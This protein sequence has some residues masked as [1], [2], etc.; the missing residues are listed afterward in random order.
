MVISCECPSFNW[1]NGMVLRCF[2]RPHPRARCPPRCAAS[3]APRRTCSRPAPPGGCPPAG[4]PTGPPCRQAATVGDG[5]QPLGGGT[6]GA[7]SLLQVLSEADGADAGGPRRD[8]WTVGHGERPNRGKRHNVSEDQR[9]PHNEQ[10]SF[11]A[12]GDK[13]GREWNGALGSVCSFKG[14]HGS[15]F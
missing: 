8:G 15:I 6:I 12:L 10:R 4:R 14:C 2:A 13:V 11:Q 7:D 9:K 5:G 3:P 1:D